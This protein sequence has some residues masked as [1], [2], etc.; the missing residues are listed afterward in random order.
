MRSPRSPSATR[1]TSD[2]RSQQVA[3]HHADPIVPGRRGDRCPGRLAARLVAGDEHDGQPRGGQPSA[4]A[5]PIPDVAP[6]TT[7]RPSVVGNR[8]VRRHRPAL[9]SKP[10]RRHRRRPADSSRAA[11]TRRGRTPRGRRPRRAPSGGPGGASPSARS[12]PSSTQRVSWFADSRLGRRVA[13]SA[14]RTVPQRGAGRGSDRLA[15]RRD[16]LLERPDRDRWPDGRIVDRLDADEQCVR[17]RRR[18]APPDRGRRRARSGRQSDAQ[19]APNASGV[20]GRRVARRRDAD[21]D[22]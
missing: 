21:D 20:A 18:T 6:V 11:S 17:H 5:T 3:E 12:A 9:V 10:A 16:R 15:Q 7:G 13:A 4:T 14:P 22:P 19:N 2:G 8:C 1:R